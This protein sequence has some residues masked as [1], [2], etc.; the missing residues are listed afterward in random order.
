MKLNDEWRNWRKESIKKEKKIHSNKKNEDKIKYKKQMRGHLY[1]FARRRE[2]K[3]WGEEKS[4]SYLNNC[5]NVYTF[6]TT[7]EGNVSSSN[8]ASYVVED[9]GGAPH[10]SHFGFLIIFY[11]N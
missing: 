6:N 3:E 4:S 9:G 8:N 10:A 1:I 11:I 2:I 7:E 5:T